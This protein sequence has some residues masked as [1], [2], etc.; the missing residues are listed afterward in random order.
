M[1]TCDDKTSKSG[2][3]GGRGRRPG[4]GSGKARPETTARTVAFLASCDG[5]CAPAVS[6]ECG[7]NSTVARLWS[8]GPEG[9]GAPWS[10]T[11]WIADCGCCEDDC[12]ICC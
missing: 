12:R 4:R 7:I 8:S 6:T 11:A 3:K 2:T 9:A 1:N 10:G 5:P